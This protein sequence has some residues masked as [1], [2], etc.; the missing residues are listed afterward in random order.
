[1]CSDDGA[2]RL[3]GGAFHRH[4]WRERR[5]AGI[6]REGARAV[7]L[8]AGRFKEQKGKKLFIRLLVAAIYCLFK[9]GNAVIDK[10]MGR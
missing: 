10:A 8:A 6:R 3:P 9:A 4:I 2:G 5:A 1:M 7:G